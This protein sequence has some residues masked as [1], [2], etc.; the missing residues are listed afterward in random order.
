MLYSL[1]VAVYLIVCLLLLVVVFLMNVV[2]VILVVEF[3]LGFLF[4]DYV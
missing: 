4:Y 2:V 3:V 1:G